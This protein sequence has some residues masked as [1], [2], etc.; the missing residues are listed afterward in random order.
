MDGHPG[1]VQL[2]STTNYAAL[3][4]STHAHEFLQSP[5]LPISPPTTE[6]LDNKL[7]GGK[8]SEMDYSSSSARNLTFLPLH[9]FPHM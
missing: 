4:V 3:N 1:Y 5:G 9:L 7:Y 2:W 6:L 8:N